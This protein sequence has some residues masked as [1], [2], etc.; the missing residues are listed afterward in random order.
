MNDRAEFLDRPR[1]VLLK[2]FT[3]KMSSEQKYVVTVVI[4]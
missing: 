2:I 1:S 3:Y 4:R